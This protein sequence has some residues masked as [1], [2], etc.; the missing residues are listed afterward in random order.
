MTTISYE[1]SLRTMIT[2]DK[3]AVISKTVWDCIEQIVCKL[4]E[5]TDDEIIFIYDWDIETHE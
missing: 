5:A 2:V 3:N 4:K 1:V